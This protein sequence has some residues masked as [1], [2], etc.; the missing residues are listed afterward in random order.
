[1]L[2]EKQG[3]YEFGPFRLDPAQQQLFED[4]KPASLTPKAF[5]TLLTLVRY[6]PCVDLTPPKVTSTVCVKLTCDSAAAADGQ[7]PTARTHRLYLDLQAR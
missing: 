7:S 5:D 6:R 2:Q 3:F 4:G 1:M